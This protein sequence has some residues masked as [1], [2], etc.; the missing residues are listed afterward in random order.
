MKIKSVQ[1]FEQIQEFAPSALFAVCPLF[2]VRAI[3]RG[4]ARLL[5]RVDVALRGRQKISVT[6]FAGF[7][8]RQY[9]PAQNRNQIG[10]DQARAF[11]SILRRIRFHHERL[12]KSKLSAKFILLQFRRAFGQR[13]LPHSSTLSFRAL[14]YCFRKRHA[15]MENSTTANADRITRF[16][17]IALQGA[18]FRV[19]PR[20]IVTR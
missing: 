16:G 14:R 2:L 7:R 19:T 12:R 18:F 9:H 1:I 13:T 5:L 8:S 6:E 11:V 10:S 3:R 17:H 4:G 15:L 20:T